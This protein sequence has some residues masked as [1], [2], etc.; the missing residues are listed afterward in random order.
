MPSTRLTV[1]PV[2]LNGLTETLHISCFSDLHIDSALCDYDR[3]RRIAAERAQLPHHH[4]IAIGDVCDLVLPGDLKRFKPSVRPA[5]LATRDDFLRASIDFAI[6]RLKALGLK[7]DLISRGNHEDE[8]EKRYGVDATSI[9]AHELGAS[10]GGYSGLVHYQI[11]VSGYKCA[12][13]IAYHHGAWGGKYAKGYIGAREWFD[14]LWGWDVAVYG[15]NH[16]SRLDVELRQELTW[17]KKGMEIR[18][19]RVFILN[20]ASFVDYNNADGT[21]YMERRGY[22]RQ[23]SAPPLI[24]IRFIRRGT[25]DGRRLEPD[26]RIHV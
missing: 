4:A 3:L 19:R 14:H 6:E 15:H 2:K 23:P 20:C 9:I 12:F 16:A 26:I 5:Q 1:V 18:D 7:W 24:S 8:V 11:E 13:T 21:H 10:C 25:P 22:P 17:T